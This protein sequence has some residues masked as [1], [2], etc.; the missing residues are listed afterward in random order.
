MLSDVNGAKSLTSVKLSSLNIAK[1]H[2]RTE[3]FP[4]VVSYPRVIC[5]P[6]RFPSVHNGVLVYCYY[7]RPPPSSVKPFPHFSFR[8]GPTATKEGRIKT[9]VKCEG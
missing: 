9:I 4:D 6:T 5:H 7:G 1:S 2:L 3:V 8:P